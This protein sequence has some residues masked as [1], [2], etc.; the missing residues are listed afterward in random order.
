MAVTG[1]FIVQDRSN[2]QYKTTSGWSS[3]VSAAQLLSNDY[4]SSLYWRTVLDTLPSGEYILIQAYS[5]SA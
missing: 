2:G 1:N 4:Q 5:V 3:D